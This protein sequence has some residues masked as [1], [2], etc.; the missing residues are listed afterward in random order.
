MIFISR[1]S[2]NLRGFSADKSTMRIVSV[3]F[4]ILLFSCGNQAPVGTSGQEQSKLLAS[5]PSGTYDP[6]NIDDLIAM[7][8]ALPKPMD[9]R[10]FLKSLKRPL[11]VNATSSTMSV[12]PAN[13]EKSPRIFIFKGNLIISMVPDGEG[14]S[15]LEF[16]ELKNDV[17]SFKGEV[18]LPVYKTVSSTD[19]FTRI[20]NGSRTTCSGCH[21]SEQAEFMIGSVQV[22][23]SKA[24]KP[25]ASMDVPVA[26]LANENYLCGFRGDTSKRCGFLSALFSGG[27]VTQGNFPVDMPTLLNAF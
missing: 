23:S 12:Q 14:S 27:T 8:N 24:L 19:P 10:C 5:C 25:S 21:T 18:S 9:A 16:S 2:V 11:V 7:I 1:K 15:L 6:E 3:F 20:N 22:Y 17:R 26:T 13:G 4:L